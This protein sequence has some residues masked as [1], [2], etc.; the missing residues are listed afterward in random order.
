MR[1]QISRLFEM[2]YILL[3]RERVTAPELAGRLGVSVRTVYR[4]AQALCEAG[5]PLYAERG[6][7]GGIAI[8]PTY[9][10]SKSV[11]SDAER[12]EILAS[13]QAMAQTG[14]SQTDTLR[15]LRAFFGGTIEDWVQIDFADWSGQR[16]AL[17]ATL[18]DAILSRQMLAFDYY[19]ESGQCTQRRVCPLRLW[20]KGSTWYLAAYCMQRKAL[21]TFKLTRI[22]RAKPVQ[23]PFP[24]EADA[25]VPR[26]SPPQVDEQIMES[27]ELHIDGCMA[28][29]IWDDF[30]E[31]E[32]TPLEDGSYL[33]RASFP[34]GT[35]TASLILSYGEHA[36]VISPAALRD[37]IAEKIR[38]MHSLYQT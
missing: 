21:R 18:R 27:F 5:V 36:Q 13:L 3:E 17:V 16:D 30:E 19:G 31:E 1:L 32:I 23:E 9:K 33:V 28:Y 2:L 15:K 37:R 38:K 22:K 29:R 7:D 11:L 25:C 12:R 8:L 34:P 6:R 10:L 14:A 24:P 35:W 4:D 26:L 20:F